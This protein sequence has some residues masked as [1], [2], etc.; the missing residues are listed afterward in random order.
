MSIFPQNSNLQEILLM[1]IRQADVLSVEEICTEL[2]YNTR[3]KPKRQHDLTLATKEWRV[4]YLSSDGI[5]GKELTDWGSEKGNA[6]IRVMSQRFLECHGVRHWPPGN[7][8]LE[9]RRDEEK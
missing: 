4:S 8:G 2:G 9:F 5:P 7:G 3:Q 1:P 6:D